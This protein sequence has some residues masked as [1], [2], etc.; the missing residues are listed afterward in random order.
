MDHCFDHAETKKAE[1]VK[2][3]HD[4]DGEQ[5]EFCVFKERHCVVAIERNDKVIAESKEVECVS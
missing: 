1:D 3:N 5:D 2:D 4:W